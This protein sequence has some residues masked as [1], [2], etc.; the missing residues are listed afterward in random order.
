[1]GSGPVPQPVLLV[2]NQSAST[3]R[4][5]TATFGKLKKAAGAVGGAVGDAAKAGYRKARDLAEDAADGAGK[6]YDKA[7]ELAGDAASAV[8]KKL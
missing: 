8:K 2:G 6:A 3:V 1:M 5:E 7:S 4:G